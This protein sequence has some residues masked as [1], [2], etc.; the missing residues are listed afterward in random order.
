MALVTSIVEASK[1]RQ[2]THDPVECSAS[3]F[4]RNG[5]R[6]LQLDTYGSANRKN[7]GKQ[8]QT[9]QFNHDSAQQLV[10]L[11]RKSFPSVR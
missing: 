2:R 4:D 3:I 8:S 10:E 5:Q 6:Y 9:L 11:I 7:P 1:E